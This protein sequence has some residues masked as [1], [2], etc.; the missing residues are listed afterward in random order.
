MRNKWVLRIWMARLLRYLAIPV[1]F[2]VIL[3]PLYNLFRQQTQKTQLAD[4]AESLTAA[5]NTF[6][7]NM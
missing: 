4:T 2:C 6:E 5:V 7:A 1:A 3:L